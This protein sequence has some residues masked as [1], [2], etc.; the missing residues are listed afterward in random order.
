MTHSRIRQA[1]RAA[2]PELTE[3]FICAASA[4]S[5]LQRA[6]WLRI[7]GDGDWFYKGAEMGI[8]V[9]RGRLMTKNFRLTKQAKAWIA[10]IRD[11]Y[12][13]GRSSAAA[14][15][16]VRDRAEVAGFKLL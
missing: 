8:L 13:T 14:R 2:A 9:T 15:A 12:G 10:G 3:G 4:A 6:F 11:Q 5:H 7:A 16:K 1:P